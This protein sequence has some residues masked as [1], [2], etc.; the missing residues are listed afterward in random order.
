MSATAAPP[1]DH[2]G[3]RIARARKRRGFSQHG[4]SA[5]TGY[6]RSHIAQVETGHKV[7]TPAFVAAMAKGLSVDIAELYG[8]PFRGESVRDD[9]IHGSVAD[10]RRL[11]AY[12]G[13]GPDLDGPA[14]PL[15]EL[16][17]HV[18]TARHHLLEAKLTQ[19]SAA[20]PALLEELTFWAY[21]TDSPEAWRVL[22]LG[23]ALAVSLTRRLGYSGDSLAW[24]ERAQDSA[25]R[26][27]DPHLPLIATA[28]RA[29][30]LMGMSQYR[31]ALTLLDRAASQVDWELPDAGEVSGYL[32]L[33]SAIVASRL[34][35]ETAA[36]DHMA[37]A[38]E[39][40]DAG[41]A[42]APSR[43]LVQFNSA[44]VAVHGAAVAVELGDLDE[45][46]KRDRDITDEVLSTLPEERRAHH[47]IDMAR[48]HVE[49]GDY[50]R[51]TARV[52]SAERTAGQMTRYHPTARAVV[53]HLVDRRRELPQ[54]LRGIAGRMGM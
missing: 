11:L 36:W 46:S 15:A 54:P 25:L 3:S 6:S 27:Q 2:I 51:A 41:R 18:E 26:S 10:L 9:E 1:T 4:L 23:H 12:V 17:G 43:H 22:N 21:E 32:S 8:Q 47:E 45:A 5:R 28:P 30:L 16:A 19:I 14:R 7:A 29:L 38:Q 42:S 31:P 40:L 20:L 33:R 39:L 34:S 52:L 50:G 44:N 13:V 24:M 48:L 35:D 49:T 53:E 37:A